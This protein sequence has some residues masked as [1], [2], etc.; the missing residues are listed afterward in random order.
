MM[1]ALA[2]AGRRPLIALTGATGT[3]STTSRANPVLRLLTR[4]VTV[5]ACARTA[6]ARP[7][8]P[9][10]NRNPTPLITLNPK[11][12]LSSQQ[13]VIDFSHTISRTVGDV[14]FVYETTANGRRERFPAGTRG[15][16]YYHTGSTD[17]AGEVRLRICDNANSF[18]KGHDLL[19]RGVRPWFIDLLRLVRWPSYKLLVDILIKDGLVTHHT[20]DS[21][22]KIPSV[23]RG[24]KHTIF[25]LSDP[26]YIDLQSNH[27]KLNVCTEDYFATYELR[28]LFNIRK[29]GRD[30]VL[31]FAG[32]AKVRFEV[33]NFPGHASPG[34]TLVLKILEVHNLQ[35]LV[36]Q[37]HVQK[38]VAGAYHHRKYHGVLRMWKLPFDSF[39]NAKDAFGPLLDLPGVV[40][41]K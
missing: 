29:K 19:V 37:D 39:A 16:L 34:P 17:L 27:H 8:A 7:A 32:I 22:R 23:S 12:L 18:A 10:K 5:S 33:S 2:H 4:H 6:A 21:V 1:L 14:E 25:T 30:V 13:P 36:E 38:P 31:P 41:A 24:P 35:E 15:F 40:Y 20:V 11:S 3:K 28:E 9:Y 26:F